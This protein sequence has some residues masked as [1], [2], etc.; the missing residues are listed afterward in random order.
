MA[1]RTGS[2]SRELAQEAPSILEMI[3]EDYKLSARREKSSRTDFA[4]G[5]LAASKRWHGPRSAATADEPETP[6]LPW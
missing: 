1:I 3:L 5:W 6:K 4:M 2:L